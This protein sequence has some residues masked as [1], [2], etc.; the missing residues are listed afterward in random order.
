MSQI[1]VV[2]ISGKQYIVKKGSELVVDQVPYETNASFEVPVLLTY[3]DDKHTCDIGS[4]E[5]KNKAKIDVI[6]HMKGDKIRVA[7]FKAKV[8]YRTVNGFR[9]SLSRLKVVNF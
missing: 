4:P 5:L 8:R 1:A 3:D 7:K 6:E 9:P 2:A